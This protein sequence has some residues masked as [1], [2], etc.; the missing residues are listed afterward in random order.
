M[1]WVFGMDFSPGNRQRASSAQWILICLL[2]MA[3]IGRA[4]DIRLESAGARFGFPASDSSQYF[5]EAEAFVNWDLPWSWE[6]G[7]AWRLQSRVELSAG[8]I[9]RSG[10]EGG[11]G[12]VG[13]LLALG[14]GRF[15]LWL[16]AGVD[17]TG[18]T[19]TKFGAPGE[20]G[21][22]DFGIPFQFT[23][24]IGLYYDIASWLRAGVRYQHM[25]NADI[26][27][28]NPGL[29]LYEVYASYVF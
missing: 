9:G 17:A 10:R 3:G 27:S 14:H 18:L 21:F 22:K 5:R 20:V 12:S 23:S 24:H 7:S 28:P 29:N 1:T 8:W 16:E 25:S 4:Q 26:G 19:R 11:I 13:P 6:L 2:A 15:P